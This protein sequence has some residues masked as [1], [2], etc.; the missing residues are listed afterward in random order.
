MIA[1]CFGLDKPLKMKWLRDPLWVFLLLGIFLFWLDARSANDDLLI[2]VSSADVE[3]LNAQWQAQTGRAPT[4]TELDG[5]IDQFVEEEVYYR[6]ALNYKLDTDDTI[7][8]RRLVQKLTFLTEDVATSIEPTAEDLTAFYESHK[9]DYR[10]PQKYSFRHVYFSRD[11]REDA[12]DDAAKELKRIQGQFTQ[13]NALSQDQSQLQPKGDPFMLQ[14]NFAERSARE[15][16]S[17]FGV[18]FA[19]DMPNLKLNEWSKPVKSAYGHHLVL[20]HG[21]SESYTPEFQAVANRVATDYASD[22][23]KQANEKFKSSLLEKYTVE[24]PD[25]KPTEK[26]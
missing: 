21:V 2:E 16:A 10:Q 25:L 1:G 24:K 23:R 13:N 9:D 18:S 11:R 22:L 12:A 8:R 5:L 20:L 14:S 6:E 15:I 3:R 19:K 17:T 4:T 7:I 26:T